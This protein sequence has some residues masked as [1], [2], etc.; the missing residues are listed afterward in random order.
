MLIRLHLNIRWIPCDGWDC[1]SKITDST[2]LRWGCNRSYNYMVLI[3]LYLI[4]YIHKSPMHYF[5]FSLRFYVHGWECAGSTLR[6]P[7]GWSHRQ[8]LVE[9]HTDK[10]VSWWVTWFLHMSSWSLIIRNKVYGM[11][12]LH[13]LVL[14]ILS[15]AHNNNVL[16][17]FYNYWFFIQIIVKKVKHVLQPIL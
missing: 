5:S 7:G 15:W 3:V 14:V 9:H 2:I 4:L 10:V 11:Q 13:V 8:Q 17:V 12:V 1:T 16:F 6:R